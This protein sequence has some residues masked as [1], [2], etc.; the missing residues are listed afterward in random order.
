[1]DAREKNIVGWAT[2]EAIGYQEKR[3]GA[4][5]IGGRAPSLDTKHGA[6]RLGAPL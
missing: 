3:V 1:M 4:L 5:I 6:V 2:S